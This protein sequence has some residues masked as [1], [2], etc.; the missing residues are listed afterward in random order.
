[1]DD[2]IRCRISSEGAITGKWMKPPHLLA[3][4]NLPEIILVP[5]PNPEAAKRAAKV[6]TERGRNPWSLTPAAKVSKSFQDFA[7]RRETFLRIKM[8]TSLDE[9]ALFR[10]GDGFEDFLVGG[11]FD[12]SEVLGDNGHW[13]T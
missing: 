13:L 12:A 10:V 9:R 6:G 1:M 7:A 8:Q 4:P 5:L 2:E 11:E 3:S